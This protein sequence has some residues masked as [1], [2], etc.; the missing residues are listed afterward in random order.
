MK[1]LLIQLLTISLISV[2]VQAQT[3][4]RGPYLNNSDTKATIRWRT[5]FPT[6]SV[7]T[8]GAATYTDTLQTTEHS[9]KLTNLPPNTHFTYRI[10]STGFTFPADTNYHFHTAP[11]S[12]T[13][14]R[15][16]TVVGFG[17]F[18][19]NSIPQNDVENVLPQTADIWQWYGDNAY[20]VGSASDYE[21][22]V[23]GT[24]YRNHFPKLNL[25]P[26]LGNHDAASAPPTTQT[27]PYF[28]YFN[29]PTAGEYG[30]VASNTKAYY[31]YNYGHVHFLVLESTIASFRDPSGAMANWIRQ[32]LQADNSRWKVVYFH[33]PPFSKGSHDSD[34]EVELIEMRQNIAPI[35]EQFGV[36]LVLSGHCHGY[37]RSH[38]MNGF[39]G[40]SAQFNASYR[41]SAGVGFPEPYQKTTKGT[42]YAV[43]GTGGV[44]IGG[45]G[46]HNAMA[47]S[48]F[49]KYGFA[50]M[51]FTRDSLW[52]QFIDTDK[53]IVDQFIIRKS[54][55]CPEN[56]TLTSPPHTGSQT[57]EAHLTILSQ[58]QLTTGSTVW[59]SAGK[60][61]E[62]KPGFTAPAG[63]VFRAFIGGCD[64][65]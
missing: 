3:I 65:P 26:A 2:V 18:G 51:T 24:H 54:Q 34:S 11:T 62:L 44:G 31:S 50:K 19:V 43:V 10:G 37:E 35:L 16:V 30:G 61:V 64:P 53:Q 40:T 38:F 57:Y 27:G 42:V 47:K 8:I 21:T 33:H 49:N 46:I 12:G 58:N 56:L 13:Y 60:S 17:D 15:P 6:N 25:L 59:Y 4:T 63:T 7:V 1:K 52:F 48:V 9:V 28:D 14:V 45:S 55:P 41:L 22:N 20:P 36:D 39:Y 23:F 5:N 29:F 32:D